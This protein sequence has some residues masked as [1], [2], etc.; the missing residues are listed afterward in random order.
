EEGEELPALRAGGAGGARAEGGALGVCGG[1]GTVNL[2]AALAAKH[3][4]PLAVFPGGT[5]NHFAADAGIEDFAATA[6]AVLAGAGVAV[7][8]GVLRAPG[9]ERHRVFLNTFS[10][11]IYPDLVRLRER[12]EHRIGKWPALALAVARLLPAAEPTE[13]E[14]AGERRRVWLLFAGNGRYRR[15]GMAPSTRDRLDAGVLDVRLV[16]AGHRFARLR[17]VLAFLTGALDRTPVYRTARLTRLRLGGLQKV[18]HLSLDGEALPAPDALE[19]GALE[20]GL[21]VYRPAVPSRSG[22]PEHG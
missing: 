10:I 2:E 8:L 3:G 12:W 13:L 19:L 18:R 5:L 21:L 6:E 1:D 11:G 22:P 15:H 4:L 20:G 9:G 17:L 7:D 14:I 16:D